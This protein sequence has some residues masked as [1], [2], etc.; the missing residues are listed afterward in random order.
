MSYLVIAR[1]YRP[2]TFDEIV[3]QSHVTKTLKNA[4][5]SK[6]IAH[7]YL[8]SGPRGVGKTS[9]ARIMAKSLN[10]VNG[11]T[12]TPCGEC[13]IC[14]GIAKGSHVDVFEIDGA[15][16]N[17][18][19]NIR[20]IGESVKY[21]PAEARYKIY[22]I[23]EVHMLSTAAFNAL[24][25]T[26]EE[27]PP[28]II[29]IFAT[30]E[31][32][33]IPATISSRCQQFD[34][35][36]IAFKELEAHLKKIT[37]AE[38]ITVDDKALYFI[39]REAEGSLRDGQSYLD[40]VIAFSGDTITGDDVLDALGIMDRTMLLDL[41]A[42]V[43]SS[44]GK[45]CLSLIEK[46]YLFGGDFKRV[47]ADLL[48]IVRAM[49]VLKVT[50]TG[51]NLDL[52]ASEIE[53]LEKLN[54][55]FTV[56]SLQMFFSILMKG[57]EDVKRS[58]SPRYCFEMLILKA[59][60]IGTIEPIQDLINK[61]ARIKA[62]GGS[63]PA[64]QSASRGTGQPASQS[65]GQPTSVAES[66]IE[67]TKVAPSPS[68]RTGSEETNSSSSD[69]T[70]SEAVSKQPPAKP[71]SQPASGGQPA[72]GNINDFI[73]S[74]IPSIG[75]SLKT[76]TIN[77]E[78]TKVTFKVPDDYFGAVSTK[79]SRLKGFCEEFYGKQVT[80]HIEKGGEILVSASG[81]SGVTSG[82]SPAGSADDAVAS[83]LSI[84]GGKV[85]DERRRDS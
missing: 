58:T 16:N 14:K 79:E 77:L 24:L 65:S 70:S 28:H 73:A 13:N 1:K 40:Q 25:K 63:Q 64:S 3:G 74:K 26:L 27:P 49:T 53:R 20:E 75:A 10:C 15:S 12:A 5:E 18:V 30:T 52:P 21:M 39:T 66:K 34:F 84:L 44:N 78:G 22:I 81:S 69:A 62:I 37:D 72:S 55:G 59:S 68:S 7:S 11:P 71:A 29:F 61:V 36:L 9:I 41:V 76:S 23:D 8:F 31:T 4:I 60:M 67:E 42:T 54:S 57:Y 2:T 46:I 51:E 45:E 85:I 83:A 43:Q 38:K 50:G 47:T 32:H 56:D 6:R 80:V 17:S 48:D 35:K 82:S 19:D 33:K